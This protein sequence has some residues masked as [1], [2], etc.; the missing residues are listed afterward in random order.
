[1]GRSPLR[2][3][4]RT[5]L[6]VIGVVIAVIGAG[7]IVTL[8]F[9]SG[10]PGT[11]TQIRP[12]DPNIAASSNQTWTFLGPAPGAGSVS[13]SWTS[14]ALA[15]VVLLPA[16]T[17]AGPSGFCVSGTAA[18]SWTMA[19][20]GAGKVSPANASVYILE[21]ANPG[22]SPLR[23]VGVVSVAYSTGTQIPAW[24]WAL[25]AAGGIAL[26]AIGGI[27]LFL[28]LYLAAGVYKGPPGG[29]TVA[30]RHPSLPP[31]DF[32]PVPEEDLR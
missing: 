19:L 6:V 5:G 9:L 32:D 30:V 14:S 28:G 25:I 21:V 18:L 11:T 31:E 13:V 4:V 24:S 26:L 1:M 10:G 20:T 7:L 29:E 3:P 12:E 15:N 27:A 17:C 16:T 2:A 22:S 8:F 23:F